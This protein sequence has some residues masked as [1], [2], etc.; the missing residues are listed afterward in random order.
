MHE[1]RE[2][3]NYLRLANYS[4][5]ISYYIW[6]LYF[7]SLYMNSAFQIYTAIPHHNVTS[8]TGNC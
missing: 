2:S 4:S 5:L 7:P 3:T 6:V 8:V 1:Y